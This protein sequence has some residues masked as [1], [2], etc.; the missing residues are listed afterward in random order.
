MYCHHSRYIELV[1]ETSRHGGGMLDADTYTNSFSYEAAANAAGGLID[2][3]ATV[4]KGELDN[5]FALVRPPGHHATPSRAMGFCLF[6]S[7]AIAARAALRTGRRRMNVRA[8]G[9]RGQAPLF[10]LYRGK[11]PT[12]E[13][14]HADHVELAEEPGEITVLA[15]GRAA[16]M[17]PTEGR[18]AEG[19]VR[20]L[21]YMAGA[22]EDNMHL[23]TGPGEAGG[24]A[25]RV[26]GIGFSEEADAH[27]NSFN[28]C[29]LP[30]PRRSGPQ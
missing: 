26:Y 24:H 4:V 28:T 19:F 17:T 9:P 3:T 16:R 20:N 25:A 14:T 11:A 30:A 22:L 13:E 6:G 8:P 12:V 2:L 5:G 15:L 23:E 10:D 21:G 18:N 29:P 1:E 7:V 27:Y